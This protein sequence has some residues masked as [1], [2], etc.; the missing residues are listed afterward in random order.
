M[1]DMKN[2][3]NKELYDMLVFKK[4]CQAGLDYFYSRQYDL[5]SYWEQS[6]VAEYLLWLS[7]RMQIDEYKLIEMFVQC[8]KELHKR[9]I[10]DD[11]LNKIIKILDNN[12]CDLV[13]LNECYDNLLLDIK[14]LNIHEDKVKAYKFNF[15]D[16]HK[17]YDEHILLAKKILA[18]AF[19]LYLLKINTSEEKEEF[20]LD[21]TNI[22]KAF[23][24]KECSEIWKI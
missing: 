10:Q 17:V 13:L 16:V 5:K 11:N 9:Y 4:S 14:K 24:K 22:M 12:I 7:N 20:L 8:L 2:L 23:V 19:L 21:A 18:C 1:S 6:D 3:N 15:I